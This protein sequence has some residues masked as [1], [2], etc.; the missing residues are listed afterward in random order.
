MGEEITNGVSDVLKELYGVLELMTVYMLCLGILGWCWLSLRWCW[1]SGHGGWGINKKWIKAESSEDGIYIHFLDEEKIQVSDSVTAVHLTMFV[2]WTL[3]Y[4]WLFIDAIDDN[5]VHH[6]FYRTQV[7]LG[8]GLWVPVSL[9]PSIQH[10]FYPTD[11]T[12]VAG[13]PRIG[14]GP[15]FDS[16]GSENFFTKYCFP[17]LRWIHVKALE[18]EIWG[19]GLL[20]T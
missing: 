3:P 15:G 10:L 20:T 14:V 2:V 7:A 17:N 16:Q 19:P 1:T 5:D 18:V 9:T 4:R 11:A 8:S 6:S 13:S 12:R